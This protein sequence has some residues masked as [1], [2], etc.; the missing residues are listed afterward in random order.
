MINPTGTNALNPFRARANKQAGSP[1]V[2]MGTFPGDYNADNARG[3]ALRSPVIVAGWGYDIFG[4]PAPS[5]E[6]SLNLLNSATATNSVA[7][8]FANTNISDTGGT[9]AP[10]GAEVP[11][12]RYVAGALD[13]R[14]N[15]RHGVWQ[16]D[17]SFLARITLIEKQTSPPKR[18]YNIYS[19]E[20]VE[21][22]K[23]ALS[24][25]LAEPIN[26]GVSNPAKG[27]AINLSEL[28]AATQDVIY[29]E[30][31]LGTIVE[32]KS[33]LVPTT[34]SNTDITLKPIYLFNHQTNQ[35]VFLRIDWNM[36]LGY[37]APLKAAD[38]AYTNSSV[39]MCNRF[40]YRAEVVKFD[41]TITVAESHGSPWGAFVSYNP[42][43]FTQ[44]INLTEWGNPVGVRGMVA[45]GIITLEDGTT[46]T[47]LTVNLVCTGIS[48]P[49]GSKSSYPSGFSIKPISHN[50]LVEGKRL[51][52]ITSSLTAYGPIYYFS[53]A[54]AHDGACSTG[55]WP[56][57]NITQ[58]SGVGEL[59][60]VK[61]IG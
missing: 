24:T 46:I 5:V 31:P 55:I 60:I 9:P 35:N 54:N 11:A 32:I 27:K 3:M 20:E 17:P 25:A 30:V 40:L 28:T 1:T 16:T 53:M 48:V 7:K 43:I 45:P 58:D 50:T 56:R 15:Q 10:F 41:T 61:R 47:N 19:W 29:T 52:D 33:Y 12:E 36:D 39:R 4:R 49:V 38:A 2:S 23:D 8:G 22:T 14:Y 13:I 34:Q 18:F 21:V 37:P 44:A 51:S 59:T 42:Q 26:R 57:N 6:P